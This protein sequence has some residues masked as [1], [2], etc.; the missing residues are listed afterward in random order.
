M[1]IEVKLDTLN[2]AEPLPNSLYVS[3]RVGEVQKLSKFCPSRVFRVPKAAAQ[4]R[5]HGKIEVFRRIGGA[6][7]AVDS[8]ASALHQDVT[9]P[10]TDG[11]E[12]VQFKVGVSGYGQEDLAELSK[13]PKESNPKVLAAKEYLQKHNFEIRLSEAMQEL[14]RE[15]PDDPA[16]FVAAKLM[17]NNY[18]VEPR[19]VLPPEPPPDLERLSSSRLLVPLGQ[20]GEM[21]PSHEL[22]PEPPLVLVEEPLPDLE[23]LSSELRSLRSLVLGPLEPIHTNLPLV[24]AQLEAV[25]KLRNEVDPSVEPFDDLEE[26]LRKHGRMEATDAT[27][28]AAVSQHNKSPMS[29]LFARRK[30]NRVQDVPQKDAAQHGSTIPELQSQVL[31]PVEQSRTALELASDQV[32]AGVGAEDED[33]LD[34][35]VKNREVQ[36]RSHI[37][38]LAEGLHKMLRFAGW[39]THSGVQSGITQATQIKEKVTEALQK[40]TL[41]IEAHP[42]KSN[43]GSAVEDVE[44]GVRNAL[45]AYESYKKRFNVVARSL[46][47]ETDRAWKDFHALPPMEYTL[48][49]RVCPSIRTHEFSWKP[50]NVDSKLGKMTSKLKELQSAIEEESKSWNELDPV[51]LSPAK[52]LV[53]E[54]LLLQEQCEAEVEFLTEISKQHALLSAEMEQQKGLLEQQ[55]TE[56]PVLQEAVKKAIKER[57]EAQIKKDQ[58]KIVLDRA[59]TD[60]EAR[61]LRMTVDGAER[62][63]RE[64]DANLVEKMEKVHALARHFPELCA[65]AKTQLGTSL[66]LDLVPL[67]HGCRRVRKDFMDVH[68]PPWL[69]MHP[70][71]TVT[72]DDGRRCVVK[73]YPFI[74]DRLKTCLHEAALLVRLR[75]PNVVEVLSLFLDLDSDTICMRMPFYEM[76]SLDRWVKERMP[77]SISVRKAC[78]QAMVALAH[79]HTRRVVHSDLKPGNIFIDADW[80]AYLGD[81]DVSVDGATRCSTHHVTRQRNGCTPLYAAPEMTRTGA[82]TQTDIFAFGTMLQQDEIVESSPARNQLAKKMT[83]R[84]AEERPTAHA[85]LQDAFLAEALHVVQERQKCVFC[86]KEHPSEAGT[87]CQNSHF[88]CVRDTETAP[89]CLGR[90]LQSEL[91]LIMSSEDMVRDHR[92]RK[93]K[94]PCP[95]CKAAALRNPEDESCYLKNQQFALCN[96]EIYERYEASQDE[97][98]EHEIWQQK[99]EEFNRRLLELQRMFKSEQAAKLAAENV[100]ASAEF[101]RR[102]YPNALQ[103]PACGAGPVLPEGCSNLQTHHGERTAS[104]RGYISNACPCG[105]FSRDRNAWNPWDGQIR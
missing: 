31:L 18:Q 78:A 104:G 4:E 21:D 48:S 35:A 33:G 62:K 28:G 67:W 102:A 93:G 92:S 82:T 79:F 30:K 39:G 94:L 96:R 52:Y 68:R 56:V 8:G 20:L 9:I 37:A 38:R 84:A 74:K 1:S 15:R 60:R 76:G 29:F 99:Q 70:I 13:P 95:A 77:D 63:L 23:R 61:R 49:C 64:A 14:L 59:E 69:S 105:F 44:C 88:I 43:F 36:R 51:S 26:S 54:G 40:A 101:M 32:A 42:R 103:C 83:A 100:R 65:V 46:S 73:E 97:A 57:K 11:S 81:L 3:V 90:Y 50:H 47:D 5:R 24:H 2:P 66:P 16:A 27:P 45:N 22:P 71:S 58:E 7:I 34:Q 91:A 17:Q 25:K 53:S 75:H 87:V 19:L 98:R 55:T 41:F 89:G 86:F 80:N 6:S 12:D 10:L 72:T 85:A